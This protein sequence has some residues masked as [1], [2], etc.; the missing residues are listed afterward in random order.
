MHGHM[1]R[2]DLYP[3]LQSACR[4]GHST[5][6]AL[7]KVH[8][9]LLMNIDRQQLTLVVFLDLSAAFDTVDS[10]IVLLRIETIF[11]MEGA[12]LEWFISYLF[13][14]SQRIYVDGHPSDK[15][16]LNVGV[17]QESCLG[18]LLFTINASKLFEVIKYYLPDAHTYADDS[19][20]HISFTP[21]FE[22]SQLSAVKAME[23]C[24]RDIQSWMLIKLMDK[25]WTT[26]EKR[27]S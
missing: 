15:F 4:Q 12:V 13:N 11:G 17:P 21:D 1:K 26:M 8:N 18:P 5:E 22:A 6:T 10:Q 24:I 14:R 19:Q 25:L 7:L 3:L 20:L 27:N 2:F 16:P 23:L 9:D